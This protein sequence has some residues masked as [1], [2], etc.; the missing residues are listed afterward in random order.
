MGGPVEGRREGVGD[1]GRGEWQLADLPVT[2]AQVRCFNAIL[3]LTT[4]L[5]VP[6]YPVYHPT[7]PR[8][9][10]H[11]RSILR[12]VTTRQRGEEGRLGREREEGGGSSEAVSYTHLRA[13]ETE[14]DL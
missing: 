12:Y 8:I 5:T 2:R 13:H 10:Y 1:H 7:L 14:A 4:T 6:L 9:A 11:A 3:R